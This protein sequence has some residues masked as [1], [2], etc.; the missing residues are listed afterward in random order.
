VLREVIQ[1]SQVSSITN[2]LSSVPSFKSK[3]TYPLAC[4]SKIF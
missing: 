4:P 3:I 2:Q 1:S